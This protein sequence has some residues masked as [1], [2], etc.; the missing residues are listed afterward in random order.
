MR[1]LSVS[2]LLVQ[3][4]GSPSVKTYKTEGL[5][6]EKTGGGGGSLANY[7]VGKG[8]HLY[9]RSLYTFWK[10]TAPP[11]SM[12]TFDTTGRDFCEV[13]RQKTRTPL[14]ALILL[15][16]PQYIESA[17]VLATTI[18][19][20]ELDSREES[21]KQLFRSI[22]SRYPDDEELQNMMTYLEESEE[23]LQDPD[24]NIGDLL[25]IGDSPLDETVNQE[26]LYKFTTLACVLFNLE[27]TIIKS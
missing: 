24:K 12:M 7:K 15:N 11:P 5:W 18:L 23:G 27:E 16:D 2:G 4:T 9:R 20:S 10:R 19:N 6:K 13:K 26:E 8:E 22:T 25:S 17:R 1:P 14:Q 21:S 3:K